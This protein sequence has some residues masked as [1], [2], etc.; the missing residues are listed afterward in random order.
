MAFSIFD[1]FY[2]YAIAFSDALFSFFSL[3]SISSFFRCF[4]PIQLRLFHC[5]VKYFPSLLRFRL[6]FHVSFD[7]SLF[8]FHWCRWFLFF[9]WFLISDFDYRCLRLSFVMFAMCRF[10]F[11]LLRLLMAFADFPALIFFFADFLRFSAADFLSCCYGAGASAP[12][13]KLRDLLI[14]DFFGDASDWL[15][16]LFSISSPAAA[17]IFLIIIFDFDYFLAPRPIRCFHDVF[18]FFISIISLHWCFHFFS[19][20]FAALYASILR[21]S[22][23]SLP[24]FFDYCHFFSFSDVLRLFRFSRIFIDSHTSFSFS[25]ITPIRFLSFFADALL[26][27]WF[28]FRHFFA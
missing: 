2:C 21:V 26:P 4:S 7:V 28:Y 23:S 8:G 15:F 27:D 16:R 18:L 3:A 24:P 13:P 1:V 9:D 22:A 10:L 17:I 20:F 5:C 25:F 12:S 6:P 19:L 14:F 11:I